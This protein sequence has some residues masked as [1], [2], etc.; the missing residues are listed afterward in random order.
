M[1]ATVSG[2]ASG[3]AHFWEERMRYDIVMSIF[4]SRR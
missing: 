4:T 3:K 1:V 2:T